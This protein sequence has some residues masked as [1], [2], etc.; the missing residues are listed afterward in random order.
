[1]YGCWEAAAEAGVCE[2]EKPQV[3]HPAAKRPLITAS[4]T[5]CQET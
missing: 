1:M 2:Q 4:R 3:N 5:Y